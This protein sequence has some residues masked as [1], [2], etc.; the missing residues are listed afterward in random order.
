MAE[1]KDLESFDGQNTSGRAKRPEVPRTAPERQ[2][3]FTTT[4]GI[5]LERLYTPLD[6]A[7]LDY[8]SALGF[9]GE[10]PLRVVCSRRCIVG[11]IGPCASMPVSAPRRSP[12][13]AIDIF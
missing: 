11:V 6:V 13:S 12:T 10:Y 1:E 8:L 7:S 4:S 2:P 9:P 3:G 5:L